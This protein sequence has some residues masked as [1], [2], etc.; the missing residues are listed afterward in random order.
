MDNRRNRFPRTFA[1]RIGEDREDHQRLP[2]FA[3]QTRLEPIVSRDARVL[4]SPRV[5]PFAYGIS[6][7][8]HITASPLLCARTGLVSP[9]DAL[10]A[11]LLVSFLSFS[12]FS[13]SFI[14]LSREFVRIE[15]VGG[16]PAAGVACYRLYYE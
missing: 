1:A 10:Y 15:P 14:S 6:F 11:P 4:D 16:P 13:L 9:H 12:T 8:L 3:E 7:F 2:S 5:A